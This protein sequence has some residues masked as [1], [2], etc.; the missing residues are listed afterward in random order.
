MEEIK[1]IIKILKE[2]FKNNLCAIIF[3]GS[4]VKGKAKKDSD[5]DLIAIF[6]RKNEKLNFKVSKIIDKLEIEK[7]IS[8]ISVSVEDFHREKIPLYT[9][10][11]KEGKIVYGNIDLSL[12]PQSPLIKYKEF[13]SSSREFEMHKI[14]T[15]KELFKRKIYSGIPEFCYVAA[16][17][18]FQAGLAMKDAGFSSKFCVL[19]PL[20]QKYFN[21]KFADSFK[22]LFKLYTK[23]EYQLEDLKSRE[24]LQTIKL[25]ENILKE[26]YCYTEQLKDKFLHSL[27][28]KKFCK[29]CYE[30]ITK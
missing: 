9:A 4:L 6:K 3:Y 18:S 10:V 24:Y 16:K 26:I 12:N 23:S 14:E 8:L 29:N 20:V 21:K 5:I 28:R 15:A 22:K 2:K 19:L 17:H 7:E 11:K 13:F 27:H 30:K 1:K 25:A